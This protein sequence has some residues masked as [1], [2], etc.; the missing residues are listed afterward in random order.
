[1][2]LTSVHVGGASATCDY[3][4]PSPISEGAGGGGYVMTGGEGYHAEAG[5]W[6]CDTKKVRANLSAAFFVRHD[7]E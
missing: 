7:D 3:S 1:M 5:L 4:F 2:P 6:S